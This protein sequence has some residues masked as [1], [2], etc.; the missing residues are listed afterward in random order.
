MRGGGPA[1]VPSQQP[2]SVN[3]QGYVPAR[4][5]M[6]PIRRL[7]GIDE[8]HFRPIQFLHESPD[9]RQLGLAQG[10]D[11]PSPDPRTVGGSDPRRPPRSSAGPTVEI[12]RRLDACIS[13][14]AGAT[15]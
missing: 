13:G 15:E 12:R 3:D 6:S 11:L 2:V 9:D 10:S 14:P 5:A 4:F 1:A 8:T 7:R